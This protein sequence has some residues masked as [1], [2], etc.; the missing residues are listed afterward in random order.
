MADVGVGV[1]DLLTVLGE[2][3]EEVCM[4]DRAAPEFVREV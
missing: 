1:H 3:G 4:M 2:C